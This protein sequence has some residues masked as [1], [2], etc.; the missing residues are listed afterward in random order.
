MTPNTASTPCSPKLVTVIVASAISEL[1]ST[2]ARTRFTKSRKF[3][4]I[5]LKLCLS[6]S[7]S[8]GAMSP[9]WRKE[10]ATPT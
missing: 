1:R 3:T 6:T 4:M 8:A 2:P 5:S 7:W 9:P 10:I